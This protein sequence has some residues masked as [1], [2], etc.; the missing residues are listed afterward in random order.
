MVACCCFMLR[1]MFR[2]RALTSIA[3]VMGEQTTRDSVRVSYTIFDQIQKRERC[4][5]P[6]PV[7]LQAHEK[8]HCHTLDQSFRHTCN[9]KCPGCSFCCTKPFGHDDKHETAHGNMKNSTFVME[10]G[11]RFTVATNDG[12]HVR[13]VR[14]CVPGLKYEKTITPSC[15]Q[16]RRRRRGCTHHV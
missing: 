15:W 2:R 9:V 12:V 14:A 5:I 6:I 10:A 11:R 13:C 1:L 8:G 16:P 3:Q 7:W 4:C